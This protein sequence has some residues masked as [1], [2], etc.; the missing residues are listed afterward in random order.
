MI[1]IDQ[2]VKAKLRSLTDVRDVCGEKIYPDFIPQR[3]AAPYGSFQQT[4][5]DRLPSL[6]ADPQSGRHQSSVKIDTFRVDFYST[7]EYD[8]AAI[9]HAIDRSLGGVKAAGRWNDGVTQ[10]PVVTF[11]SVDDATSH[12][13]RSQLA[14]DEHP[15]AT[16]CLLTVTWL[17]EDQA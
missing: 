5:A 2:A 7:R 12:V 8:V 6:C 14:T 16:V 11:C 15:R 10:G 13:D 1:Y 17:D 3:I 9:R 4:G